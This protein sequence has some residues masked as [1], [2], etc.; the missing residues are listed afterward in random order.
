MD[1]KR[2]HDVGT[3]DKNFDVGQTAL[4]CNLREGQKWL[5]GTVVEKS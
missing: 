1:Q 2:F 3:A 5:H 4:V